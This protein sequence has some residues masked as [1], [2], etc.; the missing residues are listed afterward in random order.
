MGFESSLLVECVAAGPVVHE[1]CDLNESTEASSIL[2]ERSASSSRPTTPLNAKTTVNENSLN[3]EDFRHVLFKWHRKLF[4]T[5]RDFLA[6]TDYCS[7][8]NSII[9]LSHQIN[10]AFP[11]LK[12]DSG[13]LEKVVHE[14]K[15]KESREDL[16][17]LATRYS[18]MLTQNKLKLLKEEQFHFCETVEVKVEYAGKPVNLKRSASEI[19]RENKSKRVKEDERKD[20]RRGNERISRE[21]KDP[22]ESREAKDPKESRDIRDPRDSK[23]VR[24]PRD[25]RDGR[26]PKDNRDARVVRSGRDTRDNRD[27]DRDRERERE[28]ERERFQRENGRDRERDQRS[29][30]QPSTSNTPNSSN[31]NSRPSSSNRYEDSGRSRR[32]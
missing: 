25:S 18:A 1:T 28:R 16:K 4:S 29:V 15:A 5:V 12:D 27:R 23:E 9:F 26:D 17:V 8:K 6:S 10:G 24:D 20:S 2:S 7:I 22:K 21:A 13:E 3:W 32:Y 30:R 19:E 14:I 31:S 11:R